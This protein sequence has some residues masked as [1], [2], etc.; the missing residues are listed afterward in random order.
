M[1]IGQP[2]PKGGGVG[3]GGDDGATFD[4]CKVGYRTSRD[5]GG[6]GESDN[7]IDDA[8]DDIVWNESFGGTSKSPLYDHAGNMIGP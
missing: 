2:D 8:D 6:S 5:Q 7:D 1:P 3:F 4:D